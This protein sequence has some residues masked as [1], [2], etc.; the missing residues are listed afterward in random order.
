MIGIVWENVPKHLRVILRH[1]WEVM[2]GCFHVGLF[3][4][5]IIHDYSKFFPTEF[6]IGVRYFQG[7]RSPNAAEREEFGYSKAWMHHKGRNKHHYEYWMDVDKNKSGY[8]AVDMPTKYFVEMIMDRIA[9]CKTYR[10]KNYTDDAALEYLHM[11]SDKY[12]MNPKT[13]RRLEH[14]LT[15]LANIRLSSHTRECP[16]L[17]SVARFVSSWGMAS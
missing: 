9:A 3:W 10:G 17:I 1:K 4:Q 8:A 7:N 2:K 5:G 14:V 13:Y 12:I 6:L 15:I 11:G 16:V